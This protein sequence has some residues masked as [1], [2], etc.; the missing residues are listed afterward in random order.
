MQRVGDTGAL[1][2]ALDGQ[3][4]PVPLCSFSAQ[5]ARVVLTV[6]RGNRNAAPQ[7][8]RRLSS[9]NSTQHKNK[10]LNTYI[11][12]YV[13]VYDCKE[14]SRVFWGGSHFIPAH[15]R[16]SYISRLA[17]IRHAY[18]ISLIW[19][20]CSQG[21]HKVNPC[22]CRSFGQVRYGFMRFNLSLI[23]REQ[24]LI[25]RSNRRRGTPGRLHSSLHARD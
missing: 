22:I 4:G 25:P 17:K 3:E 7:K 14:K 9:L 8:I 21:F 15:S 5:F 6:C 1:A 18:L 10:Q 2:D 24:A 20:I 19:S 11:Y 16:G 12:I 23:S 13:Y